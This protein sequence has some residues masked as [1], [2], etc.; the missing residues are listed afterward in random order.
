V[1]GAG[2]VTRQEENISQR[3]ETAVQALV[4]TAWLAENS[5]QVRLIEV[6]TGQF[7]A[8]DLCIPEAVRI[9]GSADL[10]DKVR[11]N[12]IDRGAFEALASRL[13]ITPETIVVF[14]PTDMAYWASYALW[15]FYLHGHQ[16]LKLLNGDKT[17][18]HNEGRTLSKTQ[19]QIQ[20]TSYSTT[21]HPNTGCRVFRDE[22]LIHAEARLPIVDVRGQAEYEGRNTGGALRGGHIPGAIH[23]DWE[24]NLKADH[25]LRSVAELR[26][27]YAA[28][29]P[30]EPVITYCGA[31]IRSSHTW[32]VLR[33]L[34]GYDQVRNYDGSWREW[35]NLVDV[36]IER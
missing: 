21:G 28:I 5:H 36:P 11:R 25:T 33:F 4:S 9:N 12:I 30:T 27:L 26:Q 23:I 3:D 6:G 34:L 31:G 20:S 29:R 13:G 16:H 7:I 18:W 22:V 35:G 15:V 2:P 1:R 24:N 8:D 19:A 14:Y 32:F 17:H 10:E